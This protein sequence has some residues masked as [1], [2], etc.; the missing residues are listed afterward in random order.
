MKLYKVIKII[1]LTFIVLYKIR[2]IVINCGV[3]PK[4]KTKILIN[5]V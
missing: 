2:K 1:D 4:V 3:D 5:Y